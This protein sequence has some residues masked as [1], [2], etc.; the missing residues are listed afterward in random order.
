MVRGGV[1]GEVVHALEVHLK[2]GRKS[3][4]DGEQVAEERLLVE[5]DVSVNNRQDAV[6][7]GRSDD[8]KV[9]VR[10]ILQNEVQQFIGVGLF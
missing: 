10:Q 5:D 7:D 2:E 8:L 3:E 1:G 4:V 9:E 6:S